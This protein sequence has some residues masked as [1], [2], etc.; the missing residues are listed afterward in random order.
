MSLAAYNRK[1]DFQKTSEPVP[2]EKQV[3]HPD[4]LSFVVQR[5]HASHLH[6]DFRLEF[7]GVLK[8]WAI[9]KGPS[10]NPADKRLAVL[11]EDHPLDYARFEG[12]IP[13]GN[14]GAGTVEVW[15][16]GLWYP[17]QGFEDIG[18]ALKDRLLEFYLE[19]EYLKGAFRLMGMNRTDPKNWLLIKRKDEAAY[20]NMY[21]A[22]QLRSLGV[23]EI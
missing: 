8:S 12:T 11:V 7:D 17:A 22:N 23:K 4:R 10:M 2:E 5:H 14:Y 15:D 18:K 19:G 20:L 21:D 9:P 6:F 3:R 1:R 16:S 13:S